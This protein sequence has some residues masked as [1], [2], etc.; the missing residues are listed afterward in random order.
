MKTSLGRQL[1][2]AGYNVTPVP[3]PRTQIPNITEVLASPLLD[4]PV[5]DGSIRP[6]SI[7]SHGLRPSMRI[8]R[9]AT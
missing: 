4:G 8:I 6:W 7:R 5:A 9:R 1:Y 3:P 2:E